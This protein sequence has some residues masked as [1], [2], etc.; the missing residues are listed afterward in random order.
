MD[1]PANTHPLPACWKQRSVLFPIILIVT[2]TAAVIISLA[3]VV[4]T[5]TSS[6]ASSAMMSLA[7]ILPV[8]LSFLAVS[9]ISFIRRSLLLYSKR[10][11]TPQGQDWAVI[12]QPTAIAR[13]AM[14]TLLLYTIVPA[15]YILISIIRAN[16]TFGLSLI[17]VL[18]LCGCFCVLSLY[19]G[20]QLIRGK[21]TP[22]RLRVDQT[23]CHQYTHGKTISISWE[24]ISDVFP[25]DFDK[26]PV[27]R[28]DSD[29]RN[30]WAN[31]TTTHLRYRRRELRGSPGSIIFFIEN[32][33]IDPRALY[34]MIKTYSQDH[35]MRADRLG[36]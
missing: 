28:I 14:Y 9:V 36:G 18:V 34:E 8:T 31:D 24:S 3:S 33:N 4:V 5:L 30:R 2:S 16:D 19:S 26:R 20:I 13:Y 7:L 32:I 22:G 21:L 15:G 12:A 6:N 11:P 23:G 25:D 27:L 10:T 35:R 29:G 17:L 1:Y